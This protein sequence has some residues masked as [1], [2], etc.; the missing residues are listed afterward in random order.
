[1]STSITYL[2]LAKNEPE[3]EFLISFLKKNKSPED[4]IVVLSDESSAET[5]ATITKHNVTVVSHKFSYSFSEHRN[6]AL[7]YCKGDY[8]LALD[9]D[10][11][12]TPRFMAD[13]KE[14][15]TI[16]NYPDLILL[17]RINIVDGQP[18]SVWPDWQTRFFKNGKGIHWEGNLHERLKGY[19]HHL[20]MHPRQDYAII[21]TKTSQKLIETNEAYLRN[22]TAEENRGQL[23]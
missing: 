6:Y 14:L 23:P 16:S 10:E 5:L 4:D 9:A 11:L 19:G 12:L 17:P 7:P 1:M 3:I 13:V 22:Y 8:I 2:V 15:L 21:H 18:T 20:F